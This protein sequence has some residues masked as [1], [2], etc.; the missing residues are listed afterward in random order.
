V[1]RIETTARTACVT[2]LLPPFADDEPGT[3]RAGYFN[4]YNQGK[5]S[6][7]LDFRKPEAVA[8]GY[9]LVQHCDVVTDNF[10][11]GVIDKL[12]FGYEKLR[13]FKP[14]I[15]QIS[16]SGYGQSGPF[17]N[18]LGYGP[19]ASAL[20]GLFGS[21]G[22]PGGEPAEIGVSYPDPNAGLMGAYAIMAAVLHRERTGLGQYIDQSQWEAVLA[23]MSEGLLEWDMNQREPVRSGN[24][25]RVMSPHETYKAEGDHDKWVSIAVGSEEEWSALCSAMGQPDLAVDARFASALLRKQ[26]E[27]ALDEIVTEWTRGDRWRSPDLAAPVSRRTHR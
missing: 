25:D 17:R 11:A 6:I 3:G 16:M 27:V 15:I 22:Y 23:H 4:Q 19:P 21:S 14:D 5:R 9:E 8:L 12:G 24:H 7:L 13:A 10:S 1:I 2:R 20:S 18:F 26:N